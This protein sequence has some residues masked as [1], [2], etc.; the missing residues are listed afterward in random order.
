[1]AILTPDVERR[2][3]WNKSPVKIAFNTSTLT[4]ATIECNTAYWVT[5]DQDV[6]FNQGTAVLTVNSTVG[7][8]VW[9]RTYFSMPVYA[10]SGTATTLGTIGALGVNAAGTLWLMPASSDG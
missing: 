9:A 4:T 5:S 6:Y 7:K 10:P 1:M 3:T 2:A 8:V